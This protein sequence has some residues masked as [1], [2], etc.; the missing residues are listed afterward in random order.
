MI[1]RRN[2]PLPL[3]QKLYYVYVCV[4]LAGGRGG[5]C[6]KPQSAEQRFHRCNRQCRASSDLGGTNDPHIYSWNDA[7]SHFCRSCP[8]RG[9]NCRHVETPQRYDHQLCILRR[10]QVLR[11]CADGRV[12]GQV[13]RHDVRH[14][15]SYKGEVKKLDEGKTYTGKASVKGNTLSLSGC[16]MGGLIC[17]SESLTRQ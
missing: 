5:F 17:K 1:C 8:C 14:R 3:G 11:Y 4:S 9:R 2:Y 13:H 10:Q 15:G 12:Q 7:C 6:F 16:V